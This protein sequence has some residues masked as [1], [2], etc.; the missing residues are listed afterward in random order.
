M[1]DPVS[2][3]RPPL[4]KKVGMQGTGLL[5]GIP[6]IPAPDYAAMSREYQLVDCHQFDNTVAALGRLTAD[7]QDILALFAG[8]YTANS[9]EMR[10]WRSRLFAVLVELMKLDSS[11]WPYVVV[12]AR[13]GGM[14]DWG[15]CEP[16]T[17]FDDFTSLKPNSQGE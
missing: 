10:S 4:R 12:M 1:S 16:L 6:E 8:L 7:E 5:L 17:P 11:H 14:A 2:R 15:G 13:S 3:S 9:P